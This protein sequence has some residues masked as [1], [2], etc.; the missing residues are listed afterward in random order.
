MVLGVVFLALGAV[1]REAYILCDEVTGAMILEETLERLRYNRE[2]KK[3]ETFFE[4]LGEKEGNPRLWL[5]KYQLELD[6]GGSRSSGCGA[7]GD[8]RLQMEMKNF[9]PETFLRKLEAFRALRR[10][11]DDSGS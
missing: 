3:D 9:E 5:G 2:E 11:Q 8:W 1:I 10:G 4:A 7:A 6:M